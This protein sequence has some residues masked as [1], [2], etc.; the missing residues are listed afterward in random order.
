MTYDDLERKR[1]AR[2]AN[3]AKIAGKVAEVAAKDAKNDTSAATVAG[4]AIKG[5]ETRKCKRKITASA[6][7]LKVNMVR[8][9]EAT[10]AQKTTASRTSNASEPLP[11][12]AA[13]GEG[14]VALEPWRA[15]V[16]QMWSWGLRTVELDC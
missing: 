14:E 12:I 15:L 8:I 10:L 7:A 4:G 16:A 13:P 11:S 3:D 5:K 1:V 2:V 6:A 9:N